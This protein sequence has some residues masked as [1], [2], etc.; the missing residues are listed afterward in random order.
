M[1]GGAGDGAPAGPAEDPPSGGAAAER[2]EARPLIPGRRSHHW[3]RDPKKLLVK[4]RTGDFGEL[5]ERRPTQN[6]GSI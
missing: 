6:K 5:G 1:G 4:E 3:H 2:T